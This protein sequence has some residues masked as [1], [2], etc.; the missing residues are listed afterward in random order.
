MYVL[1]ST[2]TIQTYLSSYMSPHIYILTENHDFHDL[3]DI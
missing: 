2:D 1:I 3:G